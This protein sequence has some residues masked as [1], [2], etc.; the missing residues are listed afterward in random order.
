MK[1][2]RWKLRLRKGVLYGFS[3]LCVCPVVVLLLSSLRQGGAFSLAQ[4]EE[5]L[6]YRRDY[7]VWFW[8]SARYTFTILL[9]QLPICVLAGYGLS[10]YRFAGK[11]LVLGVYAV[12]LV[13]PFQATVVAQY[14]ALKYLNLIDTPWA[15]VLPNIFQPLGCF[16]ILQ[17]MQKVDPEIFEAARLDGAGEAA[18]L[19]RIFLPISRPAI[20]LLAVLQFTN[21]WALIDQPLLFLASDQLFPLS[22][23]LN[24]SSFGPAV[25]AAG[26]IF[27]IPPVLFYLAFSLRLGAEGETPFAGGGSA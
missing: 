6:L 9:F 26:V 3:A 24:S 10:Q 13:L 14:S 4:Y 18:V 22:I 1:S 19:G 23:E 25:G 2:E 16:L 8:N 17:Q 11:K 27:A 7:Y 12:L 15:V 20:L 5:I 21:N